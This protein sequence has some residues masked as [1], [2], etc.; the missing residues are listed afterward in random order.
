MR[1][2]DDSKMS[3]PKNPSGRKAAPIAPPVD[4]YYQIGMMLPRFY[5]RVLDEEGAYLG[6]MRRSQI[7]DLLVLRK[8][9]RLRLERSPAAPKYKLKPDEIEE[10]E[11][12]LWHCRVEIK[13]L[14]DLLRERTGNIL[15]RPWVI[16]ALNEWIG[17]PAGVSD[18]EDEAP[19]TTFTVRKRASPPP[20]PPPRRPAK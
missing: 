5:L 16:L 20:P 18:L 7:L 4:G 13:T 3:E 9:G 15:A 6:G 2:Q 8:A 19:T 11:R 1:S 17:L 14:F 10:L 12:Y